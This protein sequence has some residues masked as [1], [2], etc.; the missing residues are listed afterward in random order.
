MAQSIKRSAI[1]YSTMVQG[2]GKCFSFFLLFLLLSCGAT[3][4]GDQVLLPFQFKGLAQGTTYQVTY[5]AS[6]SVVTAGDLNDI[7]LRIDSSLSVYKPYSVISRF[8]DASEKIKM[9]THLRKVLEK[10]AVI[11]RE[12]KGISD[13][14]VYPLVEA[15]GFGP[16]RSKGVPDSSAIR[17][18]LPCVG[19]EKI[20][21]A[22][23][24]LIKKL[25]CVKID[26]NGIAQ[27]YT[28][29]VISSILEQHGIRNYL[30]E[31]GGEIRSRGLKQ[32]GNTSFKIGI[33][34]PAGDFDE[35]VIKR[36]VEI[37]NGAVTTSGNYRRYY[38]SDGRIISHLINPKTGY[39]LNN[40]LISVT[41]FANDAITADGYDN[42][43]MGMGLKD[44]FSFLE[45]HKDLQAHFI[46]RT[47][48]GAVA[49]TATTGFYKMF[50]DAETATSAKD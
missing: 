27:G 40:E 23:D 15:W 16:K 43:L 45:K 41:V 28:V 48:S 29:D 22:G 47:Q 13:V 26:L 11:Y 17:S 44:A 10:S 14:T 1:Q 31:V 24:W 35:T 9:D 5:Y 12:T 19:A 38:E 32:P 25:P 46:F 7:F 20:E 3:R 6:D 49:D 50:I 34:A 18:I 42:A 39:P 36:V 30:V 33:E 2:T 37:K 21:M 8:N 4:R